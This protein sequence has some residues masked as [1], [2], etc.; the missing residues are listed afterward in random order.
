MALL[1]AADGE[2][3]FVPRVSAQTQNRERYRGRGQTSQ[4]QLVL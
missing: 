1:E 4:R 3:V 2:Q